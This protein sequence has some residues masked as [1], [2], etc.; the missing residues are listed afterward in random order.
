MLSGNWKMRRP[1]PAALAA[2][3]LAAAAST[4]YAQMVNFSH[5][6]TIVLL[7]SP[8]LIVAGVDSR[9]T[10][11]RYLSD[12]TVTVGVRTTCK[13]ARVGDDYAIVAGLLRGD[14][15]FDVFREL[16][17]VYRQGDSIDELAGRTAA[18]IPERLSPLLTRMRETNPGA[19]RASYSGKPATQV[20]LLGANGRKPQTRIVQFVA[21]EDPAAVRAAPSILRC[22]GKCKTYGYSLGT[23]DRIAAALRADP[24]LYDHAGEQQVEKLIGL[25]QSEHPDV[26]GGP[27]A[28]V[29]ATRAGVAQIRR[30]ACAAN[31]G[32]GRL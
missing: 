25:E 20:V 3:L 11:T 30:G 29:Q 9:E 10:D 6:T 1:E 19:F 26:V 15:G 22:L 14:G 17:A 13:V 2:L 23:V 5:G 12:G 7:G 21:A 16:A 18:A 24:A 32:T 28:I 31:G 8:E 27:L 4:G